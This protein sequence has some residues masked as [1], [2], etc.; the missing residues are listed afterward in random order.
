VLRANGEWSVVSPSRI[1][2]LDPDFDVAPV[3][4]EP[5]SSLTVDAAVLLFSCTVSL[6]FFS[7]PLF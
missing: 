6:R 1:S 3:P 2:R 7:S 5:F 4:L